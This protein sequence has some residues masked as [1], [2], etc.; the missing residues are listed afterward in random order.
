MPRFFAFPNEPLSRFRLFCVCFAVGVAFLNVGLFAF[1]SALDPVAR[2]SATAAA[3]LLA[4]WWIYGY[5]RG[6]FPAAGWLVDM[7]LVGYVATYSPMPLRAL[8]VFYAGAQLRALYGPRHDLFL[9]PLS[10]GVARIVSIVAGPPDPTFHLTSLPL[11]TQI[12]ALTI[13][14][15]ALR[16]FVDATE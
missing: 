12:L 10:Y 9:L 7:L 14:S 3:V 8:G 15:S 6:G 16:L 13:I 4:V 5:R 11:A 1:D 2:W